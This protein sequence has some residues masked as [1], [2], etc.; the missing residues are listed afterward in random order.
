MTS[1][2][3]RLVP[4][5]L[6]A[7]LAAQP[8]T[9]VPVQAPTSQP[10]TTPEA[11]KPQPTPEQRIAKLKA[12]LEKLQQEKAYLDHVAK[13]GGP[14]ARV[15]EFFAERKLS[16]R[17]IADTATPQAAPAPPESPKRR[18]AR[19]MGDDERQKFGPN[20]LMLVDGLP[21]T[22]AEFDATF[23][24]A[25]GAADRAGIEDL[26]KEQTL[27]WLVRRKAAQAAFQEQAREARNTILAAQRKLAEGTDFAEVAREM[28][29]CPSRAQGGALGLVGINQGTY[30]LFYRQAAFA[31]KVGEVSDIV[32]STFG[33]HLIKVNAREED[34]QMVDTSHILALYHP[35]QAQVRGVGVKVDQGQIDLAFSDEG[36][37]KFAPAA[38]R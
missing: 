24:F 26:L 23:A 25:K 21:V 34:K 10:T 37:R 1:I 18:P 2:F 13:T 28:S 31:T 30:D 4:L 29:Q 16:A 36:L 6:A 15:Q 22:K 19:L 7:A 17:T 38:F 20:V 8:P 5:V 27:L 11:V 32:E 3:L 35:D 9:P 12:Q 33:Y 14:A